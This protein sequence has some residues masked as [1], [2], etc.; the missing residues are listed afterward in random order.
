M[1]QSSRCR[2]SSIILAE[3]C[4][5]C[6]SSAPQKLL[7][8]CFNYI[9]K[10]L[11]TICEYTGYSAYLKL[12]EGISL[13]VEICEKLLTVRSQS[14]ESIDSTFV[15]IFKDTRNTRLKRVQ[16]R[17]SK[18]L[19]HDLEILLSHNLLELELAQSKELTHNCIRHISKYGA[20]LLSLSIGEGVDIFS[21]SIFYSLGDWI[22][23]HIMN[24]PNLRRFSLKSCRELPDDFYALLLSPMSCLTYLDLSNCGSLDDFKYSEH[25]VNL[26]TLILYNVDK[27]EG[28]TEA[29]CKLK[30]LTH[31][32]ISQ[33][34]DDHRRFTKPTAT[35][36]TLVENLPHLM[37]LDISGTDLAGTGVAET[38]KARGSDI[39]GLIS[40]VSNPFHFLGLYETLHDACLR[41]DLP[42][43]LIAGNANEEQILISALAY[44]DR[45]EML[46]KVLNELF[47]LFR[48]E[49]C[50]FVGQA[51]N[52]VLEAMNRHLS[53]RH[54][55]ISGSATLF[56]I[57]KGTSSEL[58]EVVH[59]KRKIIST[60]LNGMSVHRNDETMM[61]NGCLTLCQ[62]KI[63]IDVLF[64]YERLVDVLLY[65]VHGMSSSESFVQRI[66]IYLLNSLACQVDG[67][68]KIRLGE[69]GA[70]N[71]MIWLI[72]ERLDRGYCD[73]VLEVAWSTM[74]N[75]TDETPANC[76]KFLENN[77][78]E[79][80]LSCL[81][82]FPDKEDLLR[83]MM[84]L[85]GNV[86][87]VKEL[88]HYLMHPEYLSVFSDLLESRCDGIEVSYNAAGVISHIASDG[89]D[90]WV[91]V[92]P[93]RQDVLDRM[94]KAIDSWNLESPRNINYR[95]FEPILHLVKVFHTPECQRWA[96]WALANLTKVYPEKYCHLVEKEGGLE[97]LKEISQH[98]D[99]PAAIKDLAA[100]V[101]EHCVKYKNHDWQQELDG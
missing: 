73:D 48:F 99:P 92:E 65:S 9:N 80:F 39:P 11:V 34:R 57:V 86:A 46:Q 31:L 63:P 35:L 21:H 62:F 83:N 75:I 33:S 41:H 87:E 100:I 14:L 68:Q 70:I 19:D 18:I 43:K 16:L 77:G 28:M 74:W 1:L 27:I 5:F 93:S 97:L 32:D 23:S 44:M 69:L 98:L 67:Q 101:I 47:H 40:R 10:Y 7:D 20:S 91:V 42:A 17:K 61:R 64:E 53:E 89:P 81:K 72:S 90:F 94:I 55:Q 12:K 49:T 59:V 60:L 58:H 8:L 2:H 56:Y 85:L 4:C 25:L 13:P 79:Y 54:I 22:Q 38:D 36:S 6:N 76:R 84:G 71:K 96:V 15:N 30:N 3:A 82:R 78:M 45:T 88:R 52:V 51:L 26:R 37:S 95:S 50:Q 24:V 66:G 29:I